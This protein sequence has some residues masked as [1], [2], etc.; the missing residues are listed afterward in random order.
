VKSEHLFASAWLKWGRA[1][2]HAEA[3]R[4]DIDAFRGDADADPILSFRAEYQPK[5]HGFS[6]TPTIVDLPP[7]RWGLMLGDVVSNF[8]AA[9]DHLA[10]AI[11]SR[12]SSPPGGLTDSQQ[13]RVYFPIY[14]ERDDF[15]AKLATRLP[16]A[17]RPDIAKIRALQPYRYGAKRRPFHA[18][19][20][21]AAVNNNDKH[22]AVEPIWTFPVSVGIQI[23]YSQ[24]CVF[25]ELPIRGAGL[26]I[27]AGREMAF[28][29]A[30][31]TGPDPYINID[32]NVT[33]EPCLDNRL[34]V[35]NWVRGTG[36]LIRDALR[37]FSG[38]PPEMADLDTDI[39]TPWLRLG[40]HLA[41]SASE[42]QMSSA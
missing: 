34:G 9:L 15:N 21:L 28:I 40:R 18:L 20:L 27:E 32:I 42:V 17:K 10:W 41:P 13:R 22:R 7:A 23:A 5:R 14:D 12:G 24:D 36:V 38:W 1:I 37:E 33:P 19:T 31:K 2:V 29:R 39:V 26:P 25:P 35:N 16:G 11:V 6:V 3:L 4:A 8:R 30:R